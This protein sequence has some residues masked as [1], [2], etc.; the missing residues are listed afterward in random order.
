[1][2]ILL[3]N[4]FHH[5]F[6]AFNFKSNVLNWIIF[7]EQ[8]ENRKKKLDW[9]QM[10]EI[11][12]LE[13]IGMKSARLFYLRKIYVCKTGKFTEAPIE[14]CIFLCSLYAELLSR[15]LL[16]LHVLTKSHQYFTAQR[17]LVHWLDISFRKQLEDGQSFLLVLHSNLIKYGW[18]SNFVGAEKCSHLPAILL[19]NTWHVEA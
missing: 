8:K 5:I 11:N 18:D 13:E 12:N 9:N 10:L 6:S 4:R 1:M 15:N 19:C 14:L 17:Y 3:K 2:R 16:H 7:A